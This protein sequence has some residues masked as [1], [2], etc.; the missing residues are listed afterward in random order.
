MVQK[1]KEEEFLLVATTLP[2]FWHHQQEQNGLQLSTGEKQNV[3]STM[4]LWPN[5]AASWTPP[6]PCQLCKSYPFN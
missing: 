5:M 2:G 6:V 1:S 4:A 3:S